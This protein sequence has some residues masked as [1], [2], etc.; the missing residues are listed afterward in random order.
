LHEFLCLVNPP[1]IAITNASVSTAT[2]QINPDDVVSQ[3]GADSLRLYEMFMGPL[4]DTKVSYTRLV[5]GTCSTKSKH[6]SGVHAHT[7]YSI[8][9]RAMRTTSLQVWSTRS[10]EGVHRFLARAWRAFEAGV[11]E[12]EP[13][14]EQLRDLHACIKKVGV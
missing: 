6:V 10:V 11:S 9:A 8:R 7:C 1:F 12:D 2:H 14:R 3:F 13:S 4:R 5:N